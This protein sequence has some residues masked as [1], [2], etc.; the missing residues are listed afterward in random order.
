MNTFCHASVSFFSFALFVPHLI[1]P[2]SPP[3]LF[4]PIPRANAQ[5]G[6]AS[7]CSRMLTFSFFGPTTH[8]LFPKK[9]I[10]SFRSFDLQQSSSWM[11][12]VFACA[13]SAPNLSKCLT[14][15][16]GRIYWLALYNFLHNSP[17]YNLNLIVRES[18]YNFGLYPHYTDI[19]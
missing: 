6:S 12:H 5:G 13:F 2:I 3:S 17:R 7:L 9:K 18:S 16:K 15:L 8:V 19:R 4:Y 1:L 11:R 14:F 10:T